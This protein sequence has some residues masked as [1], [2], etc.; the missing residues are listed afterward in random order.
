[1]HLSWG[2]W[3]FRSVTQAVKVLRPQEVEFG[4]FLGRKG[5]IGLGLK[6]VVYVGVETPWWQTVFLAGSS[7]IIS[8]Q[9]VL[10]EDNQTTAA[11]ER[12]VTSKVPP[13]GKINYNVR[14]KGR[15][16]EVSYCIYGHL[17]IGSLLHSPS[18]L[19]Q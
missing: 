4:V 10:L 18:G 13:K 2:L 12:Q 5:L 3:L 9:N 17:C 7:F 16:Q 14:N 1:M 15:I 8:S 19:K 6:V 11:A